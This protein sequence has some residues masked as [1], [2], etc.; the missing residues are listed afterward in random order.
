M[1]TSTS[2]APSLDVPFTVRDQRRKGF[3]TIDNEL[4]D[5]YGPQL[6]AYGLAVYMALAR[7]ANQE[8]TCWPSLATIARR[9]GMSRRQVI[10]EIDKLQALGL[11]AVELQ[12]NTKT[13]E[14]KANR[15]ILLDMSPSNS[16]ALPS[17]QQSLQG[18]DCQAPRS[19]QQSPKQ[20]LE[21]QTQHRNYTQ[22]TTTRARN[23]QDNTNT[24]GATQTTGVG[25]YSTILTNPMN[26]KSLQKTTENKEVGDSTLPTPLPP[27]ADAPPS[28]LLERQQTG[29]SALI[30]VGMTAKVAERLAEH[31][32]LDRIEEK[33]A[34]LNFLQEH[35]PDKVK[36]P[37]GWLRR[38]I[39]DNF[40]APDGFLPPA[41]QE[42]QLAVTL[43]LADF[44]LEP[45]E[46]PQAAPIPE[47]TD[48]TQVQVQY[49]TTDED[50]TL[51]AEAKQEL[52]QMGQSYHGISTLLLDTLI[53]QCT[54]DTALI[55]V[56]Q[57]FQCQRL[58]HPQ[59]VKLL[60]RILTSLAGRA[61]TPV[62][63]PLQE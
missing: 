1:T 10:R 52:E 2:S 59:T 6:G 30:V 34:Y 33:L 24:S 49:G 48:W 46:P 18:S 58:Q 20:N 5:R 23:D 15:Y 35:Q 27:I 56:P 38:A 25:A 3:F 37:C 9:T 22:K 60:A 8:S 19:D 26:A 13:G 14:H 53:L 41:A 7:F 45:S 39:E 47:A 28:P 29:A 54:A 17:D 4:L 16:Q 42:Q 21:N 63:I 36:N 32:S 57:T 50:R 31:Y 12:F 55:G 51:W 40:A 43:A 61:L 11:I 62:F 44:L